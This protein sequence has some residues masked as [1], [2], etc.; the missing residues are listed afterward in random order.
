MKRAVIVLITLLGT[1]PAAYPATITYDFSTSSLID[2]V[3]ANNEP[4]IGPVLATL[5][6]LGL[7]LTT[8]GGLGFNVGCGA[9]PCLGA[10]NSLV[11]DFEGQIRGFFSTPSSTLA[12]SFVNPGLPDTITNIFDT[13]NNLIASF[14][15]DFSY[16]GGSGP[17]S[18][19][20]VL[21]TFDAM[22]SITFDSNA[23]AVPEPS[24]LVLLAS[25]VGLGSRRLRQRIRAR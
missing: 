5:S 16:L 7:S 10:D 22:D 3:G 25:A 6:S 14:S 1:A 4:S 23:A 8:I 9:T 19:F 15:N 20:D 17:V 11:D 12:I 21:L 2:S 18:F 13:S 24:T